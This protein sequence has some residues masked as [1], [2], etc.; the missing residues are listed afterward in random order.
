MARPLSDGEDDVGEL[1]LLGML[2]LIGTEFWQRRR[3]AELAE[4]LITH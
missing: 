4:R 2:V 1:G 3:Q